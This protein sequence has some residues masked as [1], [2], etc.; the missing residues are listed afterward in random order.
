M[1]KVLLIIIC[2]LGLNIISDD[3][4]W[5]NTAD[6]LVAYWNF[7]EGS[8]T[9]VNDVTGHGHAGIFSGNPL[10]VDGHKGKALYFAEN[11]FIRIPHADDLNMPNELTLSF[12]LNA[13]SYTNSG[14]AKQIFSK[15]S[16]TLDANFALYYYGQQK[17]P[18]KMQLWATSNGVWTRETD[19]ILLPQNRWVYVTV[20]YN[21]STGGM[22][23][24]DGQP[25]GNFMG[26]GILANNLKPLM[27]GAIDGTIDDVR[28][29]NRAL[30]LDD[31][32]GLYTELP[33]YIK[34]DPVKATEGEQVRAIVQVESADTRILTM[35][36]EEIPA[37][38][39]F[40]PAS[41]TLTWTPPAQ[42]LARTEYVTFTVSD[43]VIHSTRQLP[44]IV[45]PRNIALNKPYTM[46]PAPNFAYYA[47]TE[48]G[49][50]VQL[51]DGNHVAKDFRGQQGTVG[52]QKQNRIAIT[53]DLQ[54]SMPVAGVNFSTMA[55]NGIWDVYPYGIYMLVSDDGQSWH[56]IGDLVEKNGAEQ[57]P[58]MDVT[59]LNPPIPSAGVPD[60]LLRYQAHDLRTH[61]RY[62]RFYLPPSIFW[63]VDEIEV[64]Q[65]DDSLL[66][67]GYTDSPVTV[68]D[69]YLKTLVT[70]SKLR[71][72][73]RADVKTQRESIAASSL[74]ES[75]KNE[76]LSELN[77]VNALVPAVQVP[78][79]ST[80]STIF[81]INDLQRRIFAV[82]AALWR[83][84][85]L[86]GLIVWPFFRW[87]RLTPTTL[88]K[89]ATVAP[90]VFMMA[91]EFR[92]Q[93]F[94][95][96]NAGASDVDVAFSI[97][98]LPGGT[99][100]SYITVHE[101]PFTDTVDNMP[102]AAALPVVPAQTGRF[103]VH[104]PAGL[105]R[106]IWL[107]FHPVDLPSGDYR[108]QIM[109]EGDGL[110]LSA[111]P[112][113]LKIYP[114]RFPDKPSL[115]LQGWD[116]T[117]LDGAYSV[118]AQNYASLIGHLQEH[119]VDSP[120]S[121]GCLRRGSYDA[122]GHM[123]QV[124]DAKYFKTFIDRWPNAKSYY[125]DLGFTSNFAGFE[126]GT[127]AYTRAVTEWINWWAAQL[128]AWNINPEQLILCIV[129][130]P[131]TPAQDDIV[132]QAAHVIHAAQPGMRIFEDVRWPD[133]A[134]AAPELFA[135]SQILS[136]CLETWINAP[137]SFHDFYLT[138]R[139]NGH[140]LRFYSASAPTRLLD[141]YSYNMLEAWFS[142]KYGAKGEGFWSFTDGGTGWGWNEYPSFSNYTA[143]FVFPT[144][145][146]DGKHMEATREGVEDYEYMR[147]LNDRVVALEKSGH[148]A[149]ILKT[150]RTLLDTAADRVII[151]RLSGKNQLWELPRDRTVADQ[152]RHEVLEMLT[153]LAALDTPGINIPTGDVSGDGRVTMYD[154]ALVLKYTVG[155]PLTSAQQAQADFNSDTTVDAADA[156]AIAKKAL[157]VN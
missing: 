21:A 105:T 155:G 35:T 119:F 97:E 98:G 4:A 7:D 9:Q 136:P 47:I 8:G 144:D 140:E 94:N 15:W 59:V 91:N 50:A 114:F 52:W 6:G 16:T 10:W 84:K 57:T 51:T 86:N 62:I 28:I 67:S 1:P 153:Q 142:W 82:Q 113:R 53:L 146:I 122:S 120:V 55:S 19:S 148:S 87:D 129:D 71:V 141:P 107:T 133:P 123:I 72:R 127:Q 93:A 135:V 48:P 150:A 131:Y 152:V 22:L 117:A 78:S 58:L 96:S 64:Y 34:T 29:Y 14:L 157:G 125:V 69:D 70:E 31:I 143:S 156:M 92:A 139:D 75:G 99:N 30:T 106:Q 3:A 11:N 154:A 73:L 109:L 137:Q 121:T 32:Y 132:I 49:D 45:T 88:P 76:L 138:Q 63:W 39:V 130:E 77:A 83:A 134:Q 151:A 38:A 44:V 12:W 2:F 80:F 74:A 103:T 25:Q 100:P 112:L 17:Y 68:T 90:E 18:G 37:G 116:Y 23:Y 128:K 110:N 118:T 111:F 41:R 95:L 27:L 33:F 81:P 102:V 65:G 13:R 46:D 60:Q 147:I 20:V 104:I 108:G 149:L 24:F 79:W 43:G 40:D 124:P 5:A 145:V 126:A 54:S 66:S 85:G 101:V 89:P 115:H 42:G 61:G 56:Y 36:A 26:G